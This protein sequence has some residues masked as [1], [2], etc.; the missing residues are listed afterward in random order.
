MTKEEI[1]EAG[2]IVD[3]IKALRRK[4]IAL[5]DKCKDECWNEDGTWSTK[6]YLY[7]YARRIDNAETELF[8]E[9]NLPRNEQ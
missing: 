6:Q 9:V 3:D 7:D 2:R 8:D 5:L 1:D 4:L